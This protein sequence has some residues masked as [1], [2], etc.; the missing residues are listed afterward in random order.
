MTAPE[1]A[2]ARVEL[3][4][5]Q[6]QS[7]YL[8]THRIEIR[9]VLRTLIEGRDMMTAY[10]DRGDD[11]LLTS[12][13]ALDAGALIVDCSASREV[14]ARALAAARLTFVTSHAGIRIQF[15]TAAPRPLEHGGKPAFVVPVPEQLL[16]LQRREYYRLTAPVADPLTCTIHTP[17]DA[18]QVRLHILDLSAGGLA[19]IAAPGTVTLAVGERFEDCRIDLPRAASIRA[20]LAVR[21]AFAVSLRNAVRMQRYG[22]QFVETSAKAVSQIERYILET[23]RNRKARQSGLG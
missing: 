18:R 6:D 7:R 4:Q 3:V 21:N 23:E 2:P 13:L 19:I 12:L 14:N 5:G 11:F 16:R 1:E 20:S 15:A 8:L 10:F 9:E 22:C 17:G